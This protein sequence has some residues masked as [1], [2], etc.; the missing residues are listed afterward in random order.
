MTINMQNKREQ[1]IHKKC[2]QKE[3]MSSETPFIPYLAW[4]YILIECLLDPFGVTVSLYE[5]C[6]GWSTDL[7]EMYGIWVFKQG[8]I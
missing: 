3:Y 8:K 2:S 4:N 7:T 6:P 5:I 1:Y